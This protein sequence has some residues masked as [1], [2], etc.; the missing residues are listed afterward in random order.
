MK[1]FAFAV[2]IL[3]FASF[4]RA[5]SI[6]Y[7]GAG[8]LSKGTAHISG[9]LSAGHT[10]GVLDQLIEIDDETTGQIEQGNLGTVDIV[11][12]TLR[13][14][15]LGLCFTGGDLDIRSLTGLIFKESFVSGSVTQINGN[16]FL[17]AVMSQ[18]ATLLLEDVNGNFS[19]DST[20]TTVSATTPEP[21]AL[22]LL[23][24]GLLLLPLFARRRLQ[25]Q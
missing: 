18:G 13:S 11:T 20:V 25:V 2:L 10:W 21:G 1:R 15:S 24:T 5:D 8:S 9:S 7:S 23:G 12:G 6:D 4:A 14:C 17:N 3:A 16:T 19:S 22:G